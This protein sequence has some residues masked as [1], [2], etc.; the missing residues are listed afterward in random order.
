LSSSATL[1]PGATVPASVS[2]ASGATSQT[3]T[4]TGI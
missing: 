1:D 4:A 2:I 3:F